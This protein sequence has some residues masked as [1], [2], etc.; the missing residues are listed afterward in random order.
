MAFLLVIALCSFKLGAADQPSTAQRRPVLVELFTSEGCSSCPPADALL[1]QLDA[2]QFVEGADAIVLSEHVT[3]WN[4]LGW[5][6]PF[7]SE[8][9][10]NRQMEYVK[11]LG[12]QSAYTPQAVV[13]G[14]A[15]VL[16]SDPAAL[17]RAIA[18]AATLTKVELRLDAVQF[19]GNALHFAVRSARP[20]GG[21]LTLVLADDAAQS[22]VKRGENAGRDLRHVAVVRVMKTM[23]ADAADGRPLELKLPQKLPPDPRSQGPKLRLVVFISDESSGRVLAV[24]EQSIAR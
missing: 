2:R 19:S 4:P 10:T 8:A 12:L 15:D 14:A 22:S 24:N 20:L 7:S 3:Y 16:G 5:S 13:D 1:A 17:K 9:M 21:T 11:H 23:G 6:D 18:H